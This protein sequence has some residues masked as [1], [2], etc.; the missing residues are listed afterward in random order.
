MW[1]QCS[2][3]IAFVRCILPKYIYHKKKNKIKIKKYFGRFIS[4]THTYTQKKIFFID[5]PVNG[6]QWSTRVD[7]FCF[8]VN[9]MPAF[10]LS[11]LLVCPNPLNVITTCLQGFQQGIQHRFRMNIMIIIIIIIIL[12]K[13]REKK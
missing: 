1:I 12:Q 8:E 2:R 7:D 5:F 13:K 10:T 11:G 9:L 3:N 4:H 6:I